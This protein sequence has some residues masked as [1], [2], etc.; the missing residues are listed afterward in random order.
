MASVSFH[1]PIFAG[2]HDV[3]FDGLGH[4]P[5]D[6]KTLSLLAGGRWESALASA[7]EDPREVR[8]K[9]ILITI[10]EVKSIL[11]EMPPWML[12]ATQAIWVA[13]RIVPIQEWQWKYD[14]LM[15]SL[16]LQ[17]SWHFPEIESF[18]AGLRVMGP[19]ESMPLPGADWDTD[20]VWVRAE[21]EGDALL[22]WYV[23]RLAA[24]P[25]RLGAALLGQMPD[26]LYA[27]DD[28]YA[29]IG[30]TDM[31]QIARSGIYRRASL[32]RHLDYLTIAQIRE[33]MSQRGLGVKAKK[34]AD[35]VAALIQALTPSELAAILREH[36]ARPIY[37]CVLDRA[38]RSHLEL[39]SGATRCEARQA[40]GMLDSF[41]DSMG[42]IGEATVS[43]EKVYVAPGPDPECPFCPHE[44]KAVRRGDEMPPYHPGCRCRLEVDWS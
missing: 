10:S 25:L 20:V 33:V 16:L 13:K 17:A 12:M 36:K 24:L 31:V 8:G 26:I 38:Q 22:A 23:D 14:A 3:I 44:P 18:W 43:D 11:G 21:E 35:L 7:N 39:I 32:E 37:E 28:P 34:K 9:S 4:A 27:S 5:T 40:L 41:S 6:R 15:A 2:P 1:R 29:T 30:N 19:R 42:A